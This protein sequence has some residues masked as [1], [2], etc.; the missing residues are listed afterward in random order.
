M[1]KAV[2]YTQ[3]TKSPSRLKDVVGDILSSKTTC[4]D[5]S[6]S[7]E[8]LSGFY[9]TKEEATA[10]I[11]DLKRLIDELEGPFPFDYAPCRFECR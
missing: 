4:I 1:G 2:R 10:S 7:L 11:G 8:Q 5:S 3:A 9:E 6:G